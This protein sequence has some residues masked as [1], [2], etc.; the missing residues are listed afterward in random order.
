MGSAVSVCRQTCKLLPLTVSLGNIQRLPHSTVV[1][2][3]ALTVANCLSFSPM[4]VI[5]SNFYCLPAC[6]LITACVTGLLNWFVTLEYTT[7]SIFNYLISCEWVSEWVSEWHHHTWHEHTACFV[8]PGRWRGVTCATSSA[9]VRDIYCVRG[10]GAA[11][12]SVLF[13]IRLPLSCL[14]L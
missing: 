3:F 9:G 14:K 10:G 12:L 11:H 1:V 5:R 6:N 13:W 4:P 7:V 8:F 2:S